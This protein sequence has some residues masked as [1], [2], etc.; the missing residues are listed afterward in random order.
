MAYD[1][2]IARP[3]LD[4]ILFN[5]FYGTWPGGDPYKIGAIA[6]LYG[7]PQKDIN[8]GCSGC[9]GNMLSFIYEMIKEN[10]PEVI[11]EYKQRNGIK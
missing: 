11:T 10:N 2:E 7:Y 4:A 3:H 8:Y 6:L 5:K 9:F 1:L